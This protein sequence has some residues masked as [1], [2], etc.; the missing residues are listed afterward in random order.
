MIQQFSWSGRTI[1]KVNF[2]TQ[3][4][5]FKYIFAFEGSSEML[6]LRF[7]CVCVCVCVIEAKTLKQGKKSI[8]VKDREQL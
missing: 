1:A 3:K 8:P 6:L 4:A 2:V 5:C 7:V